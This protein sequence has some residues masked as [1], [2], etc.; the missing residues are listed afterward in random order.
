M[1]NVDQSWEP[2]FRAEKVFGLPTTR[3]ELYNARGDEYV[4]GVKD[5]YALAL[6][7]LR[8]N[9]DRLEEYHG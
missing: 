3:A 9:I 8:N 6:K 4:R 2:K 5:G 1:S 7:H